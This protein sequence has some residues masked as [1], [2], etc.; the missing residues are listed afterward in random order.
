MLRVPRI[1]IDLAA[2]LLRWLLL[3]FRSS[4]SIQAENLFLRRQLA[5]YIERGVKPRRIDAATRIGLTFLSLLFD[6]RDALTVVSPAT[7]IRWHRAGWRLFWR[8]KSRP[9]RPPIPTELR[10]LIRRMAIENP[11]WGGGTDRQ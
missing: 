6:W 8:M 5:L 2:D 10:A 3:A 11:S 4:Q 9:G 7:L 1:V